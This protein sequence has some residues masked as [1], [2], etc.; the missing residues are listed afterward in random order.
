[1][2]TD[3]KWIGAELSVANAS[4]LLDT[5]RNALTAERFGA[6]AALA[7]LSSEESAKAFGL[8]VSAVD[9]D[10][11]H[12]AFKT[13]A[14]SH[15]KKQGMAAALT[16]GMQMAETMHAFME[17]IDSN[18]SNNKEDRGRFV[19]EK[20]IEAANNALAQDEPPTIIRK[21]REVDDW[22]RSADSVK[23]AGLYVAFDQGQWHTPESTTKSM[24]AKHLNFAEKLYSSAVSI[25][26]RELRDNF[27][28]AAKLYR[29]SVPS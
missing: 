25:C 8:A 27:V 11:E 9:S 29:S 18:V 13:Y 15:K 3:Q 14:K 10:F 26:S 12:R 23:Q 21:M 19:Y 7:V 5:S 2:N 4:S 20:L 24:A 28:E 6:S 1:M 17:S 16:I 22:Y